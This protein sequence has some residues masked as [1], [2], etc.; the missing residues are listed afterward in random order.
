MNWFYIALISAL[1]SAAAAIAQKK[2]LFKL[3]ALDF[4][5]LLSIINLIFCLP[6]FLNTEFGEI[7]FQSLIILYIKNILGAAAF[8][9]VMLSI[10]NMEISRA[11]PLLALTPGLVAVFAFI[12]IGET[13]TIVEISGIV[14]LLIG[15]YV[16]ESKSSQSIIEPFKIFIKSKKHHYVLIALILLSVTSILDRFLLGGEKLTPSAF[17]GFQHLFLAINFLLIF[18]FAKRNV[19]KLIKSIN[20]EFL[21]W[22]IFISFL[23]IIYRYTQ[24][25]AVKIAPVAL[26]L[27]VKRISVFFAAIIGG[28]IFREK[29]LLVRAAA[30]AIIITGAILISSS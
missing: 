23:T 5:F 12:S 10:K 19:G 26:V 6:F 29:R 1:F 8:L 13:L 7:A 27:A 20:K 16:L 11:L 14:L 25:E 4:S 2:V 24:V 15:T 3:D 30:T 18:V 28:K 22:I 9:Y 17:M 21:F